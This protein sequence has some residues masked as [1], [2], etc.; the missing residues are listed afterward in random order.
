MPQCGTKKARPYFPLFSLSIDLSGGYGLE[1]HVILL[2]LLNQMSLN[3][4]STF[5]KHILHRGYLHFEN[6]L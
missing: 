3:S 5:Q 2:K 4:T 1:N 6:D